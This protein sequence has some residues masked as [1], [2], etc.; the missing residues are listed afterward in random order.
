MKHVF[1][2][3]LGLLFLWGSIIFTVMQSDT[4]LWL[5]SAACS[6]I[7]M[8]FIS[9]WL[10]VGGLSQLG[11]QMKKGWLRYL[12]FGSLIGIGFQLLRYIVMSSTGV[13]QLL[14]LSIDI[15]SL[16]VS[17]VIL[18]ISTAYIGFA[19]E[20]VFRGY[21]INMLPTSFSNKFIVLISA[22]LFAVAH[23]IDGNFDI[24]RI[25][26]LFFAGLFFAICYIA[27]RSIWFVAGIHWF[28]D[29]SWFYLGADGG[30]SS[31][32]IVDATTNQEMLFY[33]EWIDAAL[34]FGIFLLVLFIMRRLFSK[35]TSSLDNN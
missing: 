18:L 31:S 10:K 6:I 33:Y 16:L 7:L 2:K 22:N 20:I 35:K 9:K 32:K 27:T 21:L 12:L 34:T 28:W 23:L 25:A 24:S 4:V 30:S 5:I 11:L 15:N 8:H 26:F 1:H 3:S 29:F 19:E 14:E 17:T 13:I